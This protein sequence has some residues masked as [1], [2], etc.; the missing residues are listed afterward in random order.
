MDYTKL[1]IGTEHV[2]GM[3]GYPRKRSTVTF[4]KDKDIA[5]KHKLDTVDM[6]L[7]SLAAAVEEALYFYESEIRAT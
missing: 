4:E 7:N 1:T 6:R 5:W 2:D 3:R